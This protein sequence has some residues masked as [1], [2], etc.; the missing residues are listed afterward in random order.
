LNTLFEELPTTTSPRQRIDVAHLHRMECKACPLADLPNKNPDMPATGAE[1]PLVYILGEGPG[2]TEDDEDKQFVGESGQ[3]LRTRIP[4]EFKD[5]VRFNNVVRTRPVGNATPEFVAI[6]CCRPSVVR[7]IERAQPKAIFGFGNIP[8]EWVMGN[9]LQGITMWRGRRTPVKIGKHSCWFYPM[10]HPAFLIRQQRGG[11]DISE[12]ERMFRFDLK[13]AF[14][15]VPNLP[16]AVVHTPADVWAGLECITK[17]GSA[18]LADL[19]DWLDWACE[20]PC[21]G[22]DYETDRLRPYHPSA[23]ILTASLATGEKG[24]SFPFEHPDAE[25]SEAELEKAVGLWIEF[26]QKYKGVKY[27][28]NLAFELEWTGVYFNKP[29]LIRIGKWEDTSVQASILDERKGSHKPGCFSLEFLVQQ[30]FGFNLKK[31]SNLDRKSLADVPLELV[32]RYNGG[33]SK[34]HCLLGLEQNRRLKEE[35]L[36]SVYYDEALRRVPTVVLTQIKGVPVDQKEVKR[37]QSKYKTRIKEVNARIAALPVIQKFKAIK[38]TDFQPFSSKDVRYVLETM[39]HREE[40][41]VYDKGKKKDRFGADEEVLEKIDHPLAVELVKI[42][43]A[44]KRKST[45]IDPLDK[46]DPYSLIHY[47]GLIHATFNTIFARTGRLSCE[48]PNLQNFPKREEEAKEVRKQIKAPPGCVLLT[49]DYG[50]IEARVIAMFTKDKAFCKALWENYDVHGEWADRLARAYPS[51][52]GGKKNFTDKKVMKDFRTDIKNQWTFPL[53]FGA[54]LESASGYLSIPENI[55][56]PQY[57]A[58]WREFSGV[59]EWQVKQLEFYQDHGYIECL[60]GRR[61]HGPMS[62]NK[63]YNSP[64]QGT[65][66]EIVMDGMCRLSEIGDPELQPEINI[67]D[68]LTYCRVPAD[69]VDA[70]AERVITEMLS[71]P[72]DFINVPITVEAG[73]GDNWLEIE[74]FGKF[75]SDKWFK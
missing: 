10:L 19:G 21:L 48:E 40:C 44:N 45:Y 66:A 38:H 50:Q 7:D 1:R 39:L 73:I 72:Y 46:D 43:K 69:R 12:D 20:Q 24:F 75:S 27:V 60:T 53:F 3:L 31:L 55:L 61:R 13:K 4:G 17:G 23:R 34:Y 6:E 11:G 74:E 42:R 9:S 57:E 15:E 26:L 70:I 30:Y 52:V 16:P 62:T 33:D 8:L 63:V 54:S 51:R 59:A 2:K 28:H 49:V 64:V 18:G 35:G 67:H 47:D 56:K 68:D 25:W 14:A 22:L 37:L 65:A 36:A 29:E 71:V 32:L 5:K 58:F 41:V